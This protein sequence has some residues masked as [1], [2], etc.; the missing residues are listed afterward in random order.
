MAT[1]EEREGAYI[2]SSPEIKDLYASGDVGNA[3]RQT[4][5]GLKLP[6]EKYRDYVNL[7]GDAFL[8]LEKP[9]SV[10]S[11]LMLRYNLTPRVTSDIIKAVSVAIDSKVFVIAMPNTE[12]GSTPTA[13]TSTPVAAPTLGTPTPQPLPSSIPPMRVMP[14]S[15]TDLPG[16]LLHS[17]RSTL[18][19][20]A[21]PLPPYVEQSTPKAAYN[22]ILETKPHAPNSPNPPSPPQQ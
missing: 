6:P 5:D 19:H 1:K 15:E 12:N 16:S 4:F 7:F 8:G 9:D 13:A 3:I 20:D 14:K 18:A 21:P 17:L 22:A 11:V 2:K 10:Y